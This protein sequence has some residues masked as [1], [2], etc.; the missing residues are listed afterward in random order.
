MLMGSSMVLMS[1]LMSAGKTEEEAK[2]LVKLFSQEI[3]SNYGG[4]KYDFIL[5]D[6]QPLKDAVNASQLAFMT[7]ER[8]DLVIKELSLKK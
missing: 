2:A 6:T 3:T 4:V 1:D 8:K 5:G 7:K